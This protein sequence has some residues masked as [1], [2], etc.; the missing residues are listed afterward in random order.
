MHRSAAFRSAILPG[1]MLCLLAAV[2]FPASAWG[3]YKVAFP[4][5]RDRQAI[6]LTAAAQLFTWTDPAVSA[7]PNTSGNG[8]GAT[9]RVEIS[10]Y[11]G[12]A[13]RTWVQQA[14]TWAKG[15]DDEE[16]FQWDASGAGIDP[17][18]PV[19]SNYTGLKLNRSYVWRVNVVYLGA[20]TGDQWRVFVP[21]AQPTDGASRVGVYVKF[22]WD[23][24]PEYPARGATVE[25][26]HLI[27]RNEPGT[28][29]YVHNW[30]T[31]DDDGVASFID[32]HIKK[33]YDWSIDDYEQDL[34][35][36]WIHD[37][38]YVRLLPSR[39]YRYRI[40]YWRYDA[41]KNL[42]PLFND[43]DGD[44]ERGAGEEF[45]WADGG[46]D[47]STGWTFTTVPELGGGYS[48]SNTE[49]VIIYYESQY[50][51]RARSAE[52]ADETFEGTATKLQLTHENN[53]APAIETVIAGT[54]EITASYGGLHYSHA[55]RAECYSQ[56]PY[57][58][59]ITSFEGWYTT[60]RVAREDD[61]SFS[62]IRQD[63][64]EEYVSR[65]IRTFLQDAANEAGFADVSPVLDDHAWM[66]NLQYVTIIGDAKRVAPSFYFHYN[67]STAGGADINNWIAADLFYS[68]QD[69]T[70][71]VGTTPHYQIGRI[72]IRSKRHRTVDRLGV[73]YDPELPLITKVRDYAT[74]LN[75]DAKK[76]FAYDNW[77]GR[78]VVV[79]GSTGYSTWYQFYSGFAQYLLSQRIDV[80]GGLIRD[81]FSGIKV[82]KYDLFGKN[83]EAMTSANVLAHMHN[84]DDPADVPGLLY[85]LTRG[86]RTWR[87][88]SYGNSAALTPADSINASD[89]SDTYDPDVTDGRRPLVVTCADLI[90]VFDNSIVQNSTTQ[91]IGETAMSAPGGPI[92]LIGFSTGMYG[93]TTTNTVTY[94]DTSTHTATWIGSGVDEAGGYSYPVIENG[95]LTLKRDGDADAAVMGKIE[96]VKLIAQEYARTTQAGIGN[97]FNHALGDYITAHAEDL[98]AQEQRVTSTVMGATL[99]GDPAIV[100]PMRQRS[101]A[102][103]T[104][105]ELTDTNPRDDLAVTGFDPTESYNSQ[106]MP[107][108]VI[109][110]TATFDPAGAPGT[111]VD[112]TLRVETDAD[113]VRVRVLTPF[114]QNNSYTPGHWHDETGTYWAS[115]DLEV[116]PP[117]DSARTYTFNAR[118]PSVYIVLV[119]A[120]NPAWVEGVD[121]EQ[122]RWLQE[123]WLFLQTVNEFVR[124]AAVNILVVDDDQYDRYFLNGD[125]MAHVE[126]YYINPALDAAGYV[127][128]TDDPRNWTCKPAL[129]LLNKETG[130]DEGKTE[131][132]FQYKYQYWCGN[133]F[134]TDADNGTDI[135]QGQRY[136][137]EIVPAALKSFAASRGVVVWFKGDSQNTEWSVVMYPD[138]YLI[139]HNT[140]PY[141]SVQY[142]TNY[143]DN[144][145]RLAVSDQ[146]IH[147]ESGRPYIGTFQ[148]TCLGATTQ[149]SDT[150]YTNMEGQE[151]DTLSELISDVNIVGGDGENNA[152]R[153]GEVD[154]NGTEAKTI[155]TWDV[156]SGP[157][158]ITGTGS[159]GMQNAISASGARAV[160][161]TWPF[162]SI[163][164][165]GN[166]TGDNSGRENLMLEIVKWVRSVPQPSPL[167][168]PDG[169][170]G[171]SRKIILQWTRVSEASFYRIFIGTD[172]GNLTQPGDIVV[173]DN[174]WYDPANP[175]DAGDPL[176]EANKLY[177]WR[178]DCLNP[179]YTTATEGDIWS[180]TTVASAPKCTNPDP[181][182]GE[183]QVKVNK[184]FSWSK[185]SGAVDT[186]DV[187]IL[188]SGVAAGDPAPDLPLGVNDPDWVLVSEAQTGTTYT[189]AANLDA[190][191]WY[192]WRVDTAN[193]L[194]PVPDPADPD[195]PGL[196]LGVTQGTI[197]RFGTITVPPAA[198][199]PIPP[200]GSV[201]VPTSQVLSWQA[202]DRTHPDVDNGSYDIFI[203][204]GTP[205][206]PP[207]DAVTPFNV[208]T[209]QYVPPTVLVIST[210]YYWQVRPKNFAGRQN[211]VTTWTFTTASV[212]SPNRVTGMTPDD[213]T[214]D[215][216]LDVTLTWNA[217]VGA[218]TYL[219]YL[220][221]D[222]LPG[223]PVTPAPGITAIQYTPAPI[224][225]Y[226]SVYHWRIDS[227]AA[228]GLTITP[229]PEFTFT[230]IPSPGAPEKAH[231]P[232][233]ADDATDVV[234][235][236]TLT[237]QPTP[238]LYDVYFYTESG[239]PGTADDRVS[240][241]SFTPGALTAN[242][243]YFWRVDAVYTDAQ[244]EHTIT[245][246]EWSF[247]TGEDPGPGPEPGP[248]GSTH[249]F[250]AT[251]AYEAA[252]PSADSVL[253]TNFTGRYSIPTDRWRKLNDIRRLRDVV[254]MK[255]PAGRSFVAWYYTLGPYAA[256]AIRHDE[257]AKAAVRTILL[258][259]LSTLSRVCL[260]NEE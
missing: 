129:P 57:V 26:L 160:Y 97:I 187:H 229:G 146:N 222:Q 93:A 155:F 185:G 90:T 183:E 74:L 48:S 133:V 234:L 84:P 232:D 12:S 227:V 33:T 213:G 135:M 206:P 132:E 75:S 21:M 31:Y 204:T 95:Q 2:M 36:F 15:S 154:P 29:S 60:E 11:D 205:V 76:D 207:A 66:E 80:G 41:D 73:E 27:D 30:V 224:L 116:G 68:T 198:A 186:Y 241:A 197:W 237:W 120:Q 182:P 165:I 111:N 238:G 124:D 158:T 107:V 9:Y 147:Q 40:S 239:T 191:R 257:P 72:P 128:G 219:V 240:V 32:G 152:F 217:A 49:S 193:E 188:D 79:A 10:E 200:N 28:E 214:T 167:N 16:T 221:K 178:I 249:C 212:T 58:N 177:Y 260:G 4:Y 88:W 35:R 82:R 105:P 220:G 195:D 203:W 17:L 43:R 218:T 69:D 14:D 51:D 81:A 119:Q 148:N 117:V 245:G 250:I 173:R 202:T 65:G 54:Q 176:L 162:E 56:P 255:V 201:Q 85:L 196:G 254:L 44:E 20:E 123:R 61:L 37:P 151:E 174:P 139:H 223:A 199:Q 19:E 53:H 94:P 99:I 134:D 130:E 192:F 179:D 103:K 50:G 115:A 243:E 143:L 1:I 47:S 184:V 142:L 190:D 3:A 8:T 118:A 114:K 242:T 211:T 259:P 247:T 24:H 89:F 100:M 38:D 52:E 70:A 161:F 175:Q 172:P 45:I 189:H 55:A 127:V 5:P 46:G 156:G 226:G 62:R 110:H 225:D 125:Y 170:T 104:R 101:H 246:D 210:L 108:H 96:F 252:K 126:D 106:S 163:D 7:D 78:A 39:S 98:A 34:R 258:D 215:V 140:I 77:F 171:V 145:G 113:N 153:T 109:P 67:D 235:N 180:F 209:N 230:T 6:E 136:Y 121:P 91:S 233:P 157:G 144:G 138:G 251:S 64:Y 164:H 102:D 18:D 63:L 169:A 256:T 166:L 181:A 168:P 22:I 248:S 59:E 231:T 159:S 112:V 236:P 122:W 86:E 228:D 23:Q 137:G 13:S 244:G 141:H 131:A 150:D 87:W 216:E 194:S 253:A 71:E 83:A 25:R 42:V 149:T 208:T 92:G